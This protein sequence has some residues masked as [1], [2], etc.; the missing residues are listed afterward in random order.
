MRIVILALLLSGCLPRNRVVYYPAS[1]LNMARQT[2]AQGYA[3]AIRQGLQ[4]RHEK[5]LAGI[6]AGK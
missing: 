4:W 6:L 2:T 1:N 5:E 3:E